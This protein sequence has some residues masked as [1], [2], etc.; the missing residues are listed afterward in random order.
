MN[1]RGRG[2]LEIVAVTA[3][4]FA[5]LARQFVEPA[6]YGCMVDDNALLRNWSRQFLQAMH[7]GILWPRWLPD[8]HGGYGSPTFV[9]YA[10][11]T[12]WLL[13]GVQ[14]LGT[15]ISHASAWV[16]FFAL[17]GSGLGV[18]ALGT[19]RWGRGPAVLAAI[20]A[21]ALPYRV[22][23][24]YAVGVFQSKVAVLFFPFV[25]LAAHRIATRGGGVV[26]LAV[27]VALVTL[28]HVLSGYIAILLT[29]VYVAVLAEHRGRSLARFTLG[30]VLGLALAGAYLVPA[31]VESR[32]VHMDWFRDQTW[33]R[34][35]NNFLFWI[36]T[37][38]PAAAHTDYHQQ[39]R[40]N[41]LLSFGLAAIVPLASGLGARAH[42]RELG[43]TLA[44]LGTALFL[45]SSA[46][47]IVWRWLPGLPMVLFSAR[48]ANFALILAAIAVGISLT[49]S[50][51][52]LRRV[53]VACAM[54]L[55][56]LQAATLVRRGCAD[57]PKALGEFGPDYDVVE[58]TPVAVS[59]DWLGAL[60]PGAD[61]ELAPPGAAFLTG[62]TAHERVYQVD[63]SAP[64][65][66]R[67]RLF[68][69]PGWRIEI[70]GSP[71]EHGVEPD[72]GAVTLEVPR[73]VHTIRAVFGGTWD[74]SLGWVISFLAAL[75]AA[76][77]GAFGIARGPRGP[78]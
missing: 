18:Y 41:V 36:A 60:A 53:G 47:T 54:L 48:F 51:S 58:Y 65:R 10:P 71:V 74:R 22:F 14:L 43:A 1:D 72:S 62:A 16:R 68:A 50:P 42:R 52:L 66:A 5:I 55:V 45:M 37:D 57:D 35:E 4:A 73:G 30:V 12:H 61:I 9:F 49:G 17:L 20:F 28:S 40:T 19:A 56:A 7:D 34:F 32:A 23:D 25:L 8:S 75:L 27:S 59:L 46:S 21:M 31:L 64:A 76:L 38:V 13:A 44:A 29:A 69:F 3:V 77:A 33:G 63:A 26:P 70:D 15:D 67:L 39:I 11:L 24:L 6:L 2:V 78:G